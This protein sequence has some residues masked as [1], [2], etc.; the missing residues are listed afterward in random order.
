MDLT[1]DEQAILSGSSSEAASKA[2]EIL[3]A[4][5]KI[6]GADRLIP[7]S[8]AQVAGVSYKTIGDAG[9]EFLEDFVKKGAKASVPSFLN[10]AGMDRQQWEKMGV[11]REFAAKQIAILQAYEAIGITSTCTCSPYHIGI[12]PKPGEHISW[13]ESSAI[14]FANSMLGAR[15]NRESAISAL[16]S[17]VTGKTPNFGLHL[18]ENRKAALLVKVEARMEKITDYGAAGLA[19]GKIAKEKVPAFE[20]IP[21]KSSEEKMK[22]LGAAAAAAGSVALYYAKGTTPEYVLSENFETATIEQKE[23]DEA[24]AKLQSAGSAS[25]VAIGCPHCS[26]DEVKEIAERVKGKRLQFKLWVCTS[27]K[28]K[29]E[30]E[31]AGYS[32]AIEDAGGLVVAD[33]CMVVAPLKEMGFETTG[34]NSAKAAVYLPSFCGQRIRFAD[35]GQL[36]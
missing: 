10:P 32:R 18:D 25:L 31:K 20:G 13:S 24:K 7:V 33:T 19:V 21:A 22:S 5:G 1:K 12:R 23:I 26:L 9:L 28:I 16:A 14:S 4:V 36:L 15:T 6:Y 3:C 29:E 35:I 27:G 34:V 11:P 17:A 8:S 30:A 2:M